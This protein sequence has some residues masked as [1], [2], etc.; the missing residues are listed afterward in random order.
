MLAGESKRKHVILLEM[1]QN[2]W[3]TIKLPLH[4]VRPFVWDSIQLAAAQPPLDPEDSAAITAHLERKVSGLIAFPSFRIDFMPAGVSLSLFT[5]LCFSAR[6]VLLVA[7]VVFARHRM[8]SLCVLLYL[9]MEYPASCCGGS[10]AFATSTCQGH[11]HMWDCTSFN[12]FS[13]PISF[14]MFSRLNCKT[15]HCL[16]LCWWSC[17]CRA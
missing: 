9:C 11:K 6:S 7:V 4:T 14:N 10:C 12:P 1:M 8:A 3:R 13:L 17:R 16:R 5:S 2:Q 15:K